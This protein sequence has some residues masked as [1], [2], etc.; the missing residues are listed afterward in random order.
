M[1]KTQKYLEDILLDAVIQYASVHKGK[2]KK[3]ELATWASKNVPGLEGV[4]DYHFTRPV[5][6]TDPKTKKIIQR[7]KLSA[8]RIEE[9]NK[10]RESRIRV[11]KNVLL[12]S[13]S[14]EKF[15]ELDKTSQVELILDARKILLHIS[16]EKSDLIRE[17]QCLTAK[18]KKKESEYEELLSLLEKVKNKLYSEEKR[19][20]YL[21]NLFNQEELSSMLNSIGISDNDISLELNEKSLQRELYDLLDL[22]KE[23]MKFMQKKQGLDL[24]RGIASTIIAGL[25]D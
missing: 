4:R 14:V 8:I 11:K 12:N 16:K 2:I 10:S 25:D 21:I 23:I 22:D 18:N 19:I 9:I 13:S 24:A 17:N 15:Y 5:Q 1:A 20:S 7:P 3:T 6:E